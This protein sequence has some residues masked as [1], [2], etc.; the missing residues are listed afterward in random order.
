MKPFLIPD[1]S[2]TERAY[3]A[4]FMD[5][6]GSFCVIRTKAGRLEP[7]IS[8]GQNDDRPLVWMK[9]LLGGHLYRRP[10]KPR[11]QGAW[12][13]ST[14]A[15]ARSYGVALLVAPYVMVKREQVDKML[16]FLEPL[17]EVVDGC[18]I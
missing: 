11:D 8:V 17:V 12:M 7:R 13:W 2:V 9:S 1:L 6:E 16:E 5:G 10:V 15:I 3:L 18:P 14:G 4:G